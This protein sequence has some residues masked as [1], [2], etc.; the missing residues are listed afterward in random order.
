RSGKE[1]FATCLHH[2]WTIAKMISIGNLWEKYGKR[3][4]YFSFEF[5]KEKIGMWLHHYK[6]G[7]LSVAKINGETISNAEAGRWFDSM[8][9]VYFDLN[10]N[11]FWGK[12]KH[13]PDVVEIIKTACGM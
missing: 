1:T 12:G 6:T 10:T 4:I 7:R 13:L 8:N 11:S 9:S 5:L 3:R 2:A